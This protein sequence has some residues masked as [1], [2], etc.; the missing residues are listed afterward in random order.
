[1]FE[2]SLRLVLP[3]SCPFS[4]DKLVVVPTDALVVVPTDALE[5]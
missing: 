3:S 4:G 2:N 5:P 1:M